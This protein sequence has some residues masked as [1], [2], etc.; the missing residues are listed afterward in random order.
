MMIETATVLHYENGVAQ[1]QC[2]AKNACGGCSAKQSCGTR[3]LS[4][5]AGEK[6]AP[7]FRLEV[8]VPLKA[9]EQIQVG[10]AEATLLRSVFWIYGVPLLVLILSAIGFSAL[11]SHELAVAICVLISTACAFIGVKRKINKKQMGEFTP[12][13]LGKIS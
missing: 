7:S 9:G 5:L 6:F 13:F 10:L 3:A 2:S 4:G 8:N 1:V 12:I 11:F